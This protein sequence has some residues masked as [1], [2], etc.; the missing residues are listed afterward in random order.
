[1][2]VDIMSTS[3]KAVKFETKDEID[4]VE[5]GH[6]LSAARLKSG[7]GYIWGSGLPSKNMNIYIYYIYYIYYYD[8]IN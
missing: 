1:M 4:S 7:E 5:C 6:T 8:N 2:S 3:F